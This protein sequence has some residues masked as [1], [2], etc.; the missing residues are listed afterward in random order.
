M[1]DLMHFFKK[2]GI[3]VKLV[4]T[5]RLKHAKAKKF[6]NTKWEILNPGQFKIFG[7]T[8]SANKSNGACTSLTQKSY[9]ITNYAN[10]ELVELR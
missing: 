1:C 3:S 9:S 7:M 8:H 6:K 4:L 10:M 5:Q 2:T